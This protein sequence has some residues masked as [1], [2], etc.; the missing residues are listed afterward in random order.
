MK[1]T[2]NTPP[3]ASSLTRRGA[4]R[5]K[6]VFTGVSLG[7]VV[8]GAATG[9]EVSLAFFPRQQN[10]AAT[11][12]NSPIA[13]VCK[14]EKSSALSGLNYFPGHVLLDLK[15]T[16]TSMDVDRYMQVNG[17]QVVDDA[18]VKSPIDV[19]IKFTDAFQT[20][21]AITV[22]EV[23]D[24]LTRARQESYVKSVELSTY[25]TTGSRV[26]GNTIL[27]NTID[28]WGDFTVKL[29]DSSKKAQFLANY[30]EFAVLPIAVSPGDYNVID[31]TSTFLVQY[32]VANALAVINKLKADA[33]I[34]EVYSQI[35]MDGTTDLTQALRVTTVRDSTDTTY[36][37]AFVLNFPSS[38]TEAQVRQFLVKYPQ[39]DS[40]LE[41]L[42]FTHRS[43]LL[44]I[45]VP[46]G[47]EE[48]WIRELKKQPEVVEAM[49][50]LKISID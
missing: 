40:Q 44:S 22:D 7:V 16:M 38:Y 45:A 3:P 23:N 14:T 48:C 9:Y 29:A 41:I 46:E 17:Y 34:P 31:N 15:P 8:I 13:Q 43:N 12:V 1:K 10:L 5:K 47:E 50:D 39:V 36:Q 24:T 11:S 28:R 49:H 21:N 37:A 32:K 33:G 19:T 2:D 35:S 20:Q 27:A 42:E 25:W 26:T 30:P 4:L 6:L 18:L